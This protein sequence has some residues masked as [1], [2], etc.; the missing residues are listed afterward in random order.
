M[1]EKKSTISPSAVILA[2]SGRSALVQQA[3]SSTELRT[4]A[5]MPLL[6]SE[7]AVWKALLVAN[8]A[9]PRRRRRGDTPRWAR[10]SARRVSWCSRRETMRRT[11]SAMIAASSTPAAIIHRV[12]SLLFAFG[13][14]WV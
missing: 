2:S 12:T 14:L 6:I 5:P 7:S 11:P 13:C 1:S 3:R 8:G 4:V 9:T 10:S